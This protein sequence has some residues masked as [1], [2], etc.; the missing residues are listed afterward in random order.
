MLS[1]PVKLHNVSEIINLCRE[2]KNNFKQYYQT[3]TP[4]CFVKVNL[5]WL[6][7]IQHPGIKA[8]KQV[9]SSSLPVFFFSLSLGNFCQITVFYMLQVLKSNA[10][11][12]TNFSTYYIFILHIH[13]HEQVFLT[14]FLKMIPNTIKLQKTNFTQQLFIH[15]SC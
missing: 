6:D 7:H 8:T 3:E 5:F 12:E 13:I 15:S 1:Q 9:I 4:T 11:I 10:T 2:K 14:L